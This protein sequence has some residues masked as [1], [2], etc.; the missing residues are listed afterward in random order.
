MNNYYSEMNRNSNST[1][2][3]ETLTFVQ[4]VIANLSGHCGKKNSP[5]LQSDLD[6]LCKEMAIIQL[7]EDLKPTCCKHF[8]D[9][10]LSGK[11]SKGAMR[12]FQLTQAQLEAKARKLEAV[13]L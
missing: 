7:P 12:F 5:M 6:G 8:A 2:M 10:Y 13:R 3:K 4:N 9:M 11:V 1:E